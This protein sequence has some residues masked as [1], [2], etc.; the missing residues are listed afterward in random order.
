MCDSVGFISAQMNQSKLGQIRHELL[1]SSNCKARYCATFTE[2]HLSEFLEKGET[3]KSLFFFPHLFV[4]LEVSYP[5][6]KFWQCA[7]FINLSLQICSITL[8]LLTDFMF[9]LLHKTFIPE[10]SL[11]R[12]SWMF[13]RL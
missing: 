8:L 1:S 5:L 2:F 7:L 13:V 10:I 9:I 6:V 12:F 4:L 3:R 11:R